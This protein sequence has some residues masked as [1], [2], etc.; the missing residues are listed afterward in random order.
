MVSLGEHPIDRTRITN[1]C[2]GRGASPSSVRDWIRAYLSY[3]GLDPEASEKFLW[4]GK[5][6]YQAKIPEL[7]DAFKRHCDLQ[8]WEADILANDVYTLLEVRWKTVIRM[9]KLIS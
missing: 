5:E 6:L 2:P 7:R 9:R 8:D 4:R 1:S 3:R